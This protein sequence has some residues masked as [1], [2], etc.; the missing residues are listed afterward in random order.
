MTNGTTLFYRKKRHAECGN[1]LWL[2][3]GRATKDV[4]SALLVSAMWHVLLSYNTESFRRISLNSS[5]FHREINSASSS[6]AHRSSSD[7]LISRCAPKI[8]VHAR[9]TTEKNSQYR[10]I[11]TIPSSWGAVLTRMPLGTSRMPQ[12]SLRSKCNNSACWR[13]TLFHPR[14]HLRENNA[15]KVAPLFWSF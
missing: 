14:S 11:T 4:T 10:I 8:Q 5:A 3:A 2:L 15:P 9:K 13:E 12:P 1:V 6:Y 7:L